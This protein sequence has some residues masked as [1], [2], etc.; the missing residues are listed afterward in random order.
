MQKYS[1]HYFGFVFFFLLLSERRKAFLL[2]R[3]M[4][5]NEFAAVQLAKKLMAEED[6]DEDEDEG[7]KPGSS[8]SP[9]RA[10]TVKIPTLDSK[11][12][13]KDKKGI[14]KESSPK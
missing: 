11:K 8:T 12:K 10:L 1:Y 9:S 14:R 2:K 3:K 4:H 6:E 13:A 5:Y 7:K